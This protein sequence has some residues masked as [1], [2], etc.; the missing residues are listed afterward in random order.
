MGAFLAL[1]Q[2]ETSEGKEISRKDLRGCFS[3]HPWLAG[4]FAIFLVS[5]AGLPPAAG[6]MGKFFLFGISIKAG[7]LVLPV[8][9]IAG[10]LVGAAYYL[11]TAISLFQ[12]DKQDADSTRPQS[13]GAVTSTSHAALA[14]CL[15]GVL[16]LG[17]LPTTL[18]NW[19]P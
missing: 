6:F 8:A 12:E 9:G 1:S 5:L 15:V 18:L 16:V 11:G 4:C 13:A 3:R 10:S 2:L 7:Q 19:I 14:I 17:L